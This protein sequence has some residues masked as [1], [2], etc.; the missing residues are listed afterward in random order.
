[1]PSVDVAMARSL[2]GGVWGSI[3]SGISSDLQARQ[4]TETINDVGTALGSWD[5]C[6]AVDWCRWPVIAAIIVG[7]LIILSIVICVARCLCCG[8]SCCCQFF[9][10]LKCCGNCCGA[11][12]PPGG[13]RRKY[14]D[15]PYN[16][17][18]QGYKP[19]PPMFTPAAAPVAAAP[20]QYAEFDAS[21]KG[22]ADALPAM[23]TWEG[24]GSKKVSLEEDAVELETI[25][26]P[27]AG[28]S[29]RN[30]QPSPNMPLMTHGTAGP[31]SPMSPEDAR[32][33]YGH[34]HG[35]VHG[36]G[37]AH[38]SS[39]GYMAGTGRSPDPYADPYGQDSQVQGYGQPGHDYDQNDPYGQPSSSAYG[40][41]QSYG[42]AAV[43]QGRGTPHQDRNGSFGA[44][45]AQGYHG[46]GSSRSPPPNSDFNTAY[47]RP[48]G[49][50]D[51]Y[52]Q[53][54]YAQ[55][56]YG[57]DGYGQD[58]YGAG[59]ARGPTPHRSPPHNGPGSAFAHPARST[60]S[61]APQGYRR[62]PG[63]QA[64][65]YGYNQNDAYA[66]QDTHGGSDAYGQAP[67]A[68]D[69]QRQQLTGP[70]SPGLQSNGGFDFSSGY[71]RPQPQY[72][73]DDQ[74]QVSQQRPPPSSGSETGYAGL[75]AYQTPQRGWSGV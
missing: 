54:G 45:S 72:D 67:Y 44:P 52:G 38:G 18:N 22:D 53:D 21:K 71:S 55:N 57:Q 28:Q 65:D 50:Q 13:K 73:Y 63:P 7:G 11:F 31:A 39:S 40:P 20:P 59:V 17:P 35:H 33:P 41:G 4:I 8:V 24:A 32:A 10:C 23:P 42:G 15:E 27:Q 6:M 36:H 62:S 61:P 70:A 58:G 2:R 48:Y 69:R 3:V 1:M 75:K 56:G 51:G 14:L 25:K 46:H 66:R 16:A 29:A 26:K 37:Y 30:I 60:P 47:D 68:Q 5:N 19:H 34:G 74:G 9:S 43:A 64:N 49:Q 12:D